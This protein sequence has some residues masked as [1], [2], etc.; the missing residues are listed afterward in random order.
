MNQEEI[1]LTAIERLGGRITTFELMDLH[2]S[3]YQARIKSL[4]EKL[5]LKGWILT[6]GERIRLHGRRNYMYRLIKP[7]NKQLE[8]I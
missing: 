5:I 2:V 6:E 4:R 7:E 8:L 3:Q 1:I